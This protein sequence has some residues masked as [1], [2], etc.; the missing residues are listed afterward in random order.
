V[1]APLTGSGGASPTDGMPWIAAA[2]A[3]AII[4]STGAG[5]ALSRLRRH[6]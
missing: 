1:S 2:I 4:G 5:Y 6:V 3:L